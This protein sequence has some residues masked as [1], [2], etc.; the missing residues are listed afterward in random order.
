MIEKLKALEQAIY[1]PNR[2]NRIKDIR[3]AYEVWRAGKILEWLNRF[4]GGKN[5]TGKKG[6]T[7][8]EKRKAQYSGKLL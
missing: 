2:K 3:E 6:N 5:E 1:A 7:E 8:T 4:R